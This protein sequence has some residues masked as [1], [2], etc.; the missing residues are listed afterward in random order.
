MKKRNSGDRNVA[1]SSLI[2]YKNTRYPTCQI[3]YVELRGLDPA[4]P[5]AGLQVDLLPPLPGDLLPHLHHEGAGELHLLLSGGGGDST[6]GG[7]QDGRSVSL[8]VEM[9]LAT[10]VSRGSNAETFGPGTANK[11]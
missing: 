9:P 1:L 4:P 10:V 7:R 2:K 6:G 3:Q 8:L 5:L 11:G